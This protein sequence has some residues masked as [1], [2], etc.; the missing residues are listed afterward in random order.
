MGEIVEKTSSKK[1]GVL[2]DEEIIESWKKNADPW[3]AAIR[4]EQI[5]SRKLVTNEAIIEAIASCKPNSLLDIG[6]GEGWLANRLASQG[7]DVL[8]IDV[9]PELIAQAKT[10]G[11]GQFQVLSYEEMKEGKLTR[12]FDAAV[13]NFSLLGNESV[14]LL[15]RTIPTLLKSSG[16]F[17]VQTIHP[18][19]GCGELPYMDGWREGSW[20][21]F[22]GDFTDP[23]PWYFRTLESWVQLFIDNQFSIERICEPLNPNTQKAASIIFIGRIGR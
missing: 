1:D 10:G 8:G 13:C 5:E 4:A 21:G 20:A 2:R 6:C 9:V 11:E 19:I 23:A 16:F 3:I 14:H 17:I 15:F 22:S 12:K 7:L 18:Y